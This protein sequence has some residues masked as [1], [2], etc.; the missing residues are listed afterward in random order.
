MDEYGPWEPQR[1]HS[2]LLR[3]L[4][5]EKVSTGRPTYERALHEKKLALTVN[6]ISVT[7]LWPISNEDEC[8]VAE[9]ESGWSFPQ[10]R[11]RTIPCFSKGGT[12]ATMA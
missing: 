11:R 10:K 8:G 1:C 7:R 4:R 5:S 9:S 2:G 3:I 6:D 12:Q